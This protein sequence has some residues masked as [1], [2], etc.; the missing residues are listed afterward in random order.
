MSAGPILCKVRSKIDRLKSDSETPDHPMSEY[1]RILLKLS[2]EALS[3]KLGHGFDSDAIAAICREIGQVRDLGVEIAIVV[4]AGNI[5]RGRAISS[6]GSDRVVADQMGMLGTMINGLGLKSALESQGV[7]AKVLSARAVEEFIEPF[8]RGNAVSCLEQGSVVIFVGGTGNPFFTTDTAAA[9]RAAQIGADAIL[10]GTKVDGVYDGDPVKN[11]SAQKFDT[12]T[13]GDV[14]NRGLGVMDLTAI[15]M[16][17]ENSI[18]IVVFNMTVAGTLLRVI[19]GE[20]VGTTV[21]NG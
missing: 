6:D 14:L 17:R 9:L 13:F 7:S 12:I 15:T 8:D 16:C 1:R 11:P 20:S 18:P 5:I 21:V 2:G 4:G 19:K 3:G 10:K